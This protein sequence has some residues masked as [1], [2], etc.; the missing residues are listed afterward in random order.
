MRGVKQVEAGVK[1][2][3]DGILVTRPK[4]RSS[5]LSMMFETFSPESTLRLRKAVYGLVN[6]P[7]KWWDRLQR[8]LSNR[9]FTSRAAHPCAFVQTKIN[10][11][12]RWCSCGRFVTW[13]SSTSVPLPPSSN[14]LHPLPKNLKS[15]STS[16]SAGFLLITLIQGP[17]PDISDTELQCLQPRPRAG[18]SNH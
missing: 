3:Q 17:A 18:Q 13:S 12:C 11:R 2:H 7:M 10:Q 1:R 9:G 8:S 16:S 5:Y 6:A 14:C 15:L 4:A